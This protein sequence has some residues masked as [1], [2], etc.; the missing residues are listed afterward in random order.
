MLILVKVIVNYQTPFL[1]PRNRRALTVWQAE[2]R[3]EGRGGGGLG[4][5]NRFHAHTHIRYIDNY[6]FA[7]S[8][9][10]SIYLGTAKSRADIHE[11]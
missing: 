8:L 9:A 5:I 7:Y 10:A 2:V 11:T 4:E 3:K 1:A 6:N